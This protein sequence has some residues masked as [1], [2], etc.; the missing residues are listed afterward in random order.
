MPYPAFG[1]TQPLDVIALVTKCAMRSDLT[2]EVHEDRIVQLDMLR[3]FAVLGIYWINVIIFGTPSGAYSFPT[4]I[5]HS[6]LYNIIV[7]ASSELFVEGVMRGLFS[8]MF[9]ASALILLQESKIESGGVRTIDHY[10]R[11]NIFLML[12]GLIHGYFLFSIFD[13]LFAYGL[14]G[15]FLFAARKL[16]SRRLLLIGVLILVLGDAGSSSLQHI[17]LPDL[18]SLNTRTQTEKETSLESLKDDMDNDIERY[19][20]GYIDIYTSRTESVMVQQS[21]ELYQD[22]IFDIGGMML[23]GMALF[24]LGI[25]IGARPLRFYVLLCLA[26][27]VCSIILRAPEAWLSLKSGFDPDIVSLTGKNYYNLKRLPALFGHIGL[28]SILC[29]TNFAP[30]IVKSL[31]NVGRLA[32][33]NYIMQTLISVFLFYGFGYALVGSL[34]VYQLAMVCVLVWLFQIAFSAFWVS[35]FNYGPL[36]WALRSLVRG[37]RL[38]LCRSKTEAQPDECGN[39]KAF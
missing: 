5:G 18:T 6:D 32:L 23:I 27:Y 36:E 7:W 24:K 38:P 20:S 19:K 37:R 25:L 31:A 33:T 39:G 14:I 17:L 2:M 22:F 12:F 35:R 9:G 30:F 10:F 16:S 34:E 28:I 1:C 4:T 15:M 13:V 29:K 26:G 11:R 21:S 8:V 3:G